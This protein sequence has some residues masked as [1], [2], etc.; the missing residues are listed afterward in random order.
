[1]CVP[2]IQNRE[3]VFQKYINKNGCSKNKNKEC[4]PRTQNKKCVF[5]KQKTENV[6][7]KN[8]KTRMCLPRIQNNYFAEKC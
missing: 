3:C 6:C 4:V 2:K 1:M 7:S 5:Q 8:T